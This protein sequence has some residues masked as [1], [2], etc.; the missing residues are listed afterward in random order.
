M[1]L[2]SIHRW[3]TT[4]CANDNPI[5]L[6]RR[7]IGRKLPLET[8]FVSFLWVTRT[9][10]VNC[11]FVSEITLSVRRA[12]LEWNVSGIRS[13]SVHTL[14]HLHT[15][16]HLFD[17]FEYYPVRCYR[18]QKIQ[19]NIALQFTVDI[20]YLSRRRIAYFGARF[21][22]SFF[23]RKNYWSKNVTNEKKLLGNKI[24]YLMHSC[25]EDTST[26]TVVNKKASTKKETRWHGSMMCIISVINI[27][28]FK[29]NPN[30]YE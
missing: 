30:Y 9:F 19:Y 21:Q 29:Q 1:T 16:W 7:E 13:I 2:D 8:H 5:I 14:K 4:Y 3:R 11:V 6:T 26:I 12:S 20:K 22:K 25:S 27:I 23:C 24:V 18:G 15:K 10:V 17:I 28:C